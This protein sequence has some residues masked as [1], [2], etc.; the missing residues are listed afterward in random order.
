MKKI[1]NLFVA[2]LVVTASYAV[3][4]RP[5]WQTKTQPDGT[6]IEVQLVGD[7][8]YHYWVNRDGLPVECDGNGYWQIVGDE[9][10]KAKGERLKVKGESLKAKDKKAK[11]PTKGSPKGLVL[12][13]NFKDVSF[14]S[15]NTQSAM[16]DMMNSDSYTYNGAT[17]S[18]R[19][20]F[21]DQS[22]GKYTPQFDVVGPVTLPYNLSHYGANGSDDNDLLPADIVVEACSIANALHNVDFTQ[23]DSDND[24]IVDFVYVIYAGKGEADGGAA[25][26]IRPHSWDVYSAEYYGN[27]SYGESKRK[28]DGKYLY[29][30]A[31]S[32]EIDGQ[33]GKRAGIGAIAHEFSHVI[34]MPDL[35]DIDYG[36]NYE[37]D[38]TPGAWHVMDDGSYNN[39]CKT[40]PSYTI[41]DKYYLGWLTPE[42][43]GNTAQELTLNA[44]EGYQL[45]SSNSLLT[46]TSTN[47]VYYI[48]NRQ[49]SGWDAAL[50]GHGM[51]IWKIMYNQT[52]WD[53]NG[54]NDTNGTIRYALVSASGKTTGLGTAADPFPGTSNKT[55]WSGLSGKPLKDITE[56]NGVITLTYIEKTS[57]SEPTDPEEPTEPSTPSGAVTF[58]ADVDKGNAGTDSN[59][60]T[61]YTISKNGVTMVVSS[62]ILGTYNNEMH[63]R[64][65]KN[66]TLT[67]TSTVGAI[68]SVEFTCTADGDAKYGPGCFTV[69]TGDYTYSGP[70]GTWKG[71]ADQITFTAATNQVRVTQI[72]VTLVGTTDPEDPTDPE[73]PTDPETPAAEVTFDADVDMGNASLDSNNQTAYTVSKGG[74]TLDVTKGIIGTYNNENHYRVYKSETLTL[75]S[76][77][78]N[79]VSVEFTCTANDDAK[80]GPGSFAAQ[81]GYSYSGAVGTWSGSATEVTF[82]AANNQARIT[83]IVV[84]ISGTT[85]PSDPEDPTDPEEPEVN[86]NITGLQYADAYYYE[87]DGVGYWE[88]DMY[89][90][91]D[92]DAYAYIY[93]E[94]YVAI[95]AN[96]KTAL[97]GAYDLLYTGY[98][99]SVKDSVEMDYDLPATVTIQNTDNEGNYSVKGTFVGTDG[100]TYTFD[101]VVSVWAFDFDNWEEITLDE[102]GEPTDPED[103]TDP[104]DPETPAGTVTF[105]ADVDKGNASLDATN[106]TPY[107][108][109]KDGITM[110][111]TKGI[112]GTY[113]NENHYRVYKGETL[114]LTSTVG[115]IVSVEFTC[116]AD[117][118]A[119]YGPGC[120]TVSTGDYTYS[121]PVG[122]WTGEAKEVAFTAFYNQVRATQI[123]VTIAGTI[124]GVDNLDTPTS[125]TYKILRN[126]QILIINHG[127]TYGIDGQ[128]R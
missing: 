32:G 56:K 35:Y 12:L 29:Q 98:W 18:V 16:S 6:T 88:I 125:T 13:V 96:S 60:A 73:E 44:N 33:S 106:Q 48:E 42:N 117:D 100:L 114:T 28:F 21:S 39:D 43:L 78:G 79:I 122:T 22:A 107:T 55:T 101:D 36:Q 81:D 2:M 57:T 119:K 37:N 47:T 50:P 84:T 127:K 30:Y 102:S 45:A 11:A 92:M 63:Y 123:V 124:T 83:Q 23:Y 31:C 17:G 51:L 40:P 53:D 49:N 59:N 91:F 118:D 62:G 74:V 58:D 120:F 77:V 71:N 8:F 7:E 95:Q 20:Y 128:A 38:A 87:Y 80:Y 89:K 110:D 104:T 10:M 1:F 75:T 121:G 61:E 113:N 112:I 86:T 126:G 19:K 14:N 64:V 4:A 15:G 103:P 82:T 52:A 105:D 90:D 111:V 116:T 68:A 93:P 69:S 54:P 5:G 109:S 24:N 34:G 25:N 26:T 76:S 46:A 70:V 108:V 9:A 67:V 66:Q 27:C 65:Y 94:V 115:N 3:P 72:V 99:A 97:N 41:Y 85:D